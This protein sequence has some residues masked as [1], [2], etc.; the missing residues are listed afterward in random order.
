MADVSHNTQLL[1]DIAKQLKDMDIDSKVTDKVRD[2]AITDWV[3][4]AFSILIGTSGNYEQL[5]KASED[6]STGLNK[7][8]KSVGG[9]VQS[10][11]NYY[12]RMEEKHGKEFD[13]ADLENT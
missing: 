8:V 7:V 6:A 11:A 13:T 1:L 4:P 2:L 9:T 10:V 5:R 12:K 3:W